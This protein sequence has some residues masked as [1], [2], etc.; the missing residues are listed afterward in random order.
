MIQAGRIQE[1][2]L[3]LKENLPELYNTRVVIR[4]LLDALEFIQLIDEKDTLAAI[5]F[6]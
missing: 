4:G 2:S 6:A 5:S 3:Y 1:A